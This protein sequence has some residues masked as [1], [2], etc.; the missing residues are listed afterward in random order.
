MN[1]QAKDPLIGKRVGHFD[2]RGKLGA[3]GMGVVYRAD[4]SRLGRSVALKLL[5]ADVVGDEERRLRFLRE[6]R[7]AAALSHPHIAQVFDIGQHEGAVWIAM[8]LCSGGSLRERLRG[9]ALPVD[10][11]LQIS[12]QVADALVAAQAAGVV[13][14]DLKPDNVMFDA[15]GR[16]K[17]LDFGLARIDGS[18]DDGAAVDDETVEG[19]ETQ[20]GRIL[21]T[22]GYMAPE[23]ATGQRVD[24][25]ADQFAVGVILH[26]LLSGARPFKGRSSMEVI[27]ATTRDQHPPLL[28]HKVDVKPEVQA[29]ID[30]CLQKQPD[31]RYP[32]AKALLEAIQAARSAPKSGAAEAVDGAVDVGADTELDLAMPTPATLPVAVAAESGSGRRWALAVGGVAALVGLGLWAA[33]PGGPVER[34]DRE[35]PENSAS[36]DKDETKNETE[37]ETEDA[38]PMWPGWPPPPTHGKPEALRLYRTAVADMRAGQF[39]RFDAMFKAHE[40]DKSLGAAAML[41]A[42]TLHGIGQIDDARIAY[43][44]AWDARDRMH[45]W[46]RAVVEAFEPTFRRAPAD[47]ATTLKWLQK[48]VQRYPDFAMAH[49][50]LAMTAG[51]VHDLP[52]MRQSLATTLRLDPGYHNARGSMVWLLAAIGELDKALVEASKCREVAPQAAECWVVAMDIH[53]EQGRCAEVET[54]ARKLMVVDP[55]MRSGP[56]YLA[57]ALAS[58]AGSIAA[59]K[60]M[61]DRLLRLLETEGLPP[62]VTAMQHHRIALLQ[63]DFDAA[64]AAMKPVIKPQGSV[65][66]RTEAFG[67]F[68]R[69]AWAQQEAG[70]QEEAV[71]LARRFFAAAP[72]LS[73]DPKF[74]ATGFDADPIPRMLHVLARAGAIDNA[75]WHRRMK[76]WHDEAVKGGA[77]EESQRFLW[78]FG[79]AKAVASPAEATLAVAAL[80]ARAKGDAALP[81]YF[82]GSLASAD[83]GRTFLEAGR[84]DEAERWLTRAVGECLAYYHPIKAI[85]ARFDLGRLYERRGRKSE[86][87]AMYQRVIARWGKA[88]PRSVTTE[89]ARARTRALRCVPPL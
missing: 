18:E 55:Q 9:G 80:D 65:T 50:A 34:D 14:R 77:T 83:V 10:E 84:L 58:K 1:E 47:S 44:H 56:A 6:A 8:E 7:A 33:V 4:D 31:R 46:R 2:V 67:P 63:G 20:Q 37:S 21:G 28:D 5:S 22:P 13:H 60:M 15:G 54:L 69:I 57:N 86:A 26:E 75:T 41:T 76:A 73:P 62:R 82:D 70:R 49:F 59:V 85:R 12:E 16:A 23:Q 11:A 35:N 52:L 61:S 87:C 3:G 48:V 72:A 53:A 81:K 71:Q 19:F 64:I 45:P 78:P 66:Q 24:G 74:E 25:R 79:W 88:R 32:T 30:T 29:I 38:A 36:K 68:V 27:I 40:L 39:K 51:T 89:A 42:L 17:V 43:N